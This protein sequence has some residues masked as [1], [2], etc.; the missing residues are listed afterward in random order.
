[1]QS[2]LILSR[3]ANGVSVISTAILGFEMVCLFFWH[4]AH[5]S[6]QFSISFRRLG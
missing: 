1:M 4:E 2:I 5:F 3:V 6:V